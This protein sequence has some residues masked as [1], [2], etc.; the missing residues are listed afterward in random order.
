MNETYAYYVKIKKNGSIGWLS[1]KRILSEQEDNLLIIKNKDLDKYDVIEKKPVI[2]LNKRYKL[3]SQKNNKYL[4]CFIDNEYNKHVKFY[5]DILDKNVTE[6]TAGTS[7]IYL[8][9]RYKLIP[10][11]I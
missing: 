8:I 5:D 7:I 9:N 2:Y 10:I 6:F 4:G 1:N 3:C 11:E